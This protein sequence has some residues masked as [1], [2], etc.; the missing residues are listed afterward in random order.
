MPKDKP[1]IQYKVDVNKVTVAYFLGES[2]QPRAC[3]LVERVRIS[4]FGQDVVFGG[5]T[6]RAAIKDSADYYEVRLRQLREQIAEYEKASSD[7]DAAVAL[8]K[9]CPGMAEELGTNLGRKRTETKKKK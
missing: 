7:I 6:L 1:Q 5:K 9:E 3:R 8:L 2:I 4:V